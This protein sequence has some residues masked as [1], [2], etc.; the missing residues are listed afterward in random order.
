MVIPSTRKNN[1]GSSIRT[2]SPPSASSASSTNSTTFSRLCHLVIVVAVATSIIYYWCANTSFTN[3]D[4]SSSGTRNRNTIIRYNED[5]KVSILECPAERTLTINEATSSLKGFINTTL[6]ALSHASRDITGSDRPIEHLA[7][8]YDKYKSIDNGFWAEFG[9]FNGGTLIM[10]YNQLVGGP[11]SSSE[12]TGVIAGFDSFDGLPEKWR[13]SFDQGAFATQYEKVRNSIPESVELYR[14]WFQDT[15]IDFKTNHAD[16]PAAV[17]H[18]DGDLFLS[19]TITLQ[20][21]DDRIVP[22]T[23][24]IFDELIGYPGY[25]GHEILSLWLWMNQQGASLC[26]MGHAG[27]IEDI[28]SYLNPGREIYGFSQNAWFQVLSRNGGYGETK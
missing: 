10:A 14:G 11:K 1:D 3:A 23:H 4:R 5:T 12:F 7:T 9:V 19:T 6:H 24:M 25:E 20:L 13:G 21:L 27:V 28:S 16:V 22:G 26:A 17:I 18:H 8:N 15:I 2:R